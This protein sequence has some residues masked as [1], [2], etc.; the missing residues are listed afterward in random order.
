MRKESSFNKEGISDTINTIVNFFSNDPYVSTTN[1][2]LADL[3]ER[4]KSS[5]FAALKTMVRDGILTSTPG[6]KK[7]Q[8]WNFQLSDQ[9]LDNEKGPSSVLLEYINSKPKLMKFGKSGN[10]D[11]FGESIKILKESNENLLK[12]KE[13]ISSGPMSIEE[14][15]KYMDWIFEEYI[16]MLEQFNRDLV[17]QLNKYGEKARQCKTLFDDRLYETL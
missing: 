14:A 15:K 16:P 9:V 1:S 8:G 12:E 2:L 4:P 3:I 10:E 11:S 6:K 17:S 5:C 7:N 13:Q